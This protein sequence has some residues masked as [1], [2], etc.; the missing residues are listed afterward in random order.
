MPWKLVSAAEPAAGSA[1]RLIVATTSSA[2]NGCPLL[3]ATFWRSLNVHV[4][5]VA[6]GDQLSA[7]T[8]R[9]VRSFSAQ[10]RY[11]HTS[12]IVA[13]APASYMVTGSRA[14]VGSIIVTRR[15]PPAFGAAWS[16][17]RATRWS[18]ACRRRRAESN[19]P[20][21]V[22]DNPRTLP[23]TNI[24]RRVIRPRATSSRRCWLSSLCN[25][26]SCI[27]Q[28][29][30]RRM[31]A[32]VWIRTALPRCWQYVPRESLSNGDDRF[33][34]IRDE[35]RVL[36]GWL[37]PWLPLQPKSLVVG[38]RN[39]QVMHRRQRLAGTAASAA[40]QWSRGRSRAAGGDRAAGTSA[41]EK[42]PARERR[43]GA[44]GPGGTAGGARAG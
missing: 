31:R 33:S 39:N 35:T 32:L 29:P 11:S 19:E 23:R 42:R 4:C 37:L 5:A 21:V 41:T 43:C 17:P 2:V 12:W 16:L 26:F 9:R 25:W 44:R 38:A 1:R 8:G 30:L 18:S 20:S 7:K 3:K 27:V 15:V 14:P 10:V 36:T 28:S 6:S 40:A 34:A 22:N 13:M 24:W